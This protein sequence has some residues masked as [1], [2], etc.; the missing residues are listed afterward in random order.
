MKRREEIRTWL[1]EKRG[2]NNTEIAQGSS[3]D[4]TPAS[5]TSSSTPELVGFGD[6]VS[7]RSIRARQAA[8]EEKD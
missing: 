7:L 8:L 4:I 6:A 5:S 2:E 1:R 3:S